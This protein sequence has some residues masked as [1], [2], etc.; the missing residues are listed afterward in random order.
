M[1]TA[2]RTIGPPKMGAGV[3]PHC[4]LSIRPTPCFPPRRYARPIPLTHPP[5][6]LTIIPRTSPL[7]P[8]YPL[9]LPPPHTVTYLYAAPLPQT[10][11]DD[12]DG[13]SGNSSAAGSNG[14]DDDGLRLVEDVRAEGTTNVM[15]FV[16]KNPGMLIGAGVG[17]ILLKVLWTSMRRRCDDVRRTFPPM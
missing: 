11:S 9:L 2:F 4:R 6:P 12:D 17:L 5:L 1:M 7:P 13:P 16:Q 8:T 14:S 3:A 15:G 10:S